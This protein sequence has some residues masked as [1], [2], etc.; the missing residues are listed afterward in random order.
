MTIAGSFDDEYFRNS[1]AMRAIQ[2]MVRQSTAPAVEVIRQAHA[3]SVAKINE[4]LKP[5]IAAISAE[6]TRSISQAVLP[7]IQMT[8][9]DLT[10]KTLRQ[11]QLG[12]D[13][14]QDVVSSIDYNGMAQTVAAE[15][16]ETESP[17]DVGDIQPE[18]LAEQE[19]DQMT[20]DF[21]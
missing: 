1:P 18:V 4:S 21:F 9:F 8:T 5:N 6:A 13:I 17:E 11:I 14:A 19:L 12:D 2:E 10:L 20:A 3:A 16:E 7:A 15:V